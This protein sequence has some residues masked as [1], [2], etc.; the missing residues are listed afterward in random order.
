V[1]WITA[2]NVPMKDGS[3]NWSLSPEDAA[4]RRSFEVI[5]LAKNFILKDN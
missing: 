4:L 3:K 5:N 1:N 2:Q